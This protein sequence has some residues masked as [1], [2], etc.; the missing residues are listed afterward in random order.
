M[1]GVRGTKVNNNVTLK[2]RNQ[3]FENKCY[4]RMLG[5]S[6]KEHKTN[7]YVWEQV[8]IL[9]GRQ[10]ALL[11]SVASNHG[12]A[13]YVTIRC[14]RSYYKEQWMVVVTEEELKNKRMDRPVG[15]IIA[16]HR[17][18]ERSIG[19]HHIRCICQNTSM[20]PERHGS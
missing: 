1:T 13:R 10:E 20:T 9:I 6:K 12:L 19:S 4:R 14:R 18:R 7:E 2:T 3:A 11:S 5:I 15:V 16:A 8:T 17:G